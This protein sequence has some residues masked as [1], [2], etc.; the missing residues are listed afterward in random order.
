MFKYI[1]REVYS[2]VLIELSKDEYLNQ[3]SKEFF[4][5]DKETFERILLSA[6]KENACC[7]TTHI[8]WIEV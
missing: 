2:K 7:G 1:C 5:S 3:A 8:F 4:A 6:R